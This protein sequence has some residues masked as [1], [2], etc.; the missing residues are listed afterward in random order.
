MPRIS[1]V[2]RGRRETLDMP[3]LP[4]LQEV[5]CGGLAKGGFT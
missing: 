3:G 4:W 5:L 2:Q 1:D